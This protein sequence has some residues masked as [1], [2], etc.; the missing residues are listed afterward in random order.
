MNKK[1]NGLLLAV[2]FAATVLI[3]SGCKHGMQRDSGY[4]GGGHGGHTHYRG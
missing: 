1:L 4:P 3:A 2:L